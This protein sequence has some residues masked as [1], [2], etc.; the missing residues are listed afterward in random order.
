MTKQV[1]VAEVENNLY[2][3]PLTIDKED[4]NIRLLV[5]EYNLGYFSNAGC[6]YTISGHKCL[7]S[8][9]N[10]GAS[11]SYIY[12]GGRLRWCSRC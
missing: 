6:E 5:P 3:Q 4:M 2:Y 8:Y 1:G 12:T 7:R 10:L 9:A 11:R